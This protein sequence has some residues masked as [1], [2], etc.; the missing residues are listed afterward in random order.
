[1]S[2]SIA[3]NIEALC[4][5]QGIDRDLVIEAM[6]EAVRAAAKNFRDV[7]VVV[8]PDD[9]GRVLEALEQPG[10]ASLGEIG[11]CL[12]LCIIGAREPAHSADAY[13]TG[14]KIARN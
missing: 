7:L 6:K 11:T 8:E 10:G 4:Q 3:Q 13:N 12:W 5:D 1:M 2:S 14:I 9:Y